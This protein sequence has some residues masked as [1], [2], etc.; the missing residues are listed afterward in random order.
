MNTICVCGSVQCPLM[1]D[2]S[3]VFKGPRNCYFFGTGSCGTGYYY[4]STSIF[5]PTPVYINGE[6]H[7]HVRHQFDYFFD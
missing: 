7:H 5:L 1:F 3:H 6:L 2:A 4:D